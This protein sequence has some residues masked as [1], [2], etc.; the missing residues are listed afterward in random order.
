MTVISVNDFVNNAD[1]YFDMAMNEDIFIK[2]E[3]DTF[4][5]V[6]KCKCPNKNDKNLVSEE[7]ICDGLE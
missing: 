7:N 3:K 6:Y 5:L 2:T 4:K 1:K